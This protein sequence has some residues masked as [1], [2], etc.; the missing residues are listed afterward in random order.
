MLSNEHELML[1]WLKEGRARGVGPEPAEA[2]AARSQ[3]IHG[4]EEE[5]VPSLRPGSLLLTPEQA[6]EDLV[7]VYLHGGGFRSGTT[8]KARALAAQLA[9]LTG[10]RVL[11][12][13]YRLA[14]QHPYPAGLD[15]CEAGY[16]YAAARF[17]YA[18]MVLGG[19]SAGANLALALL[20]RRTAAEDPR[21]LAGFLYSGM[22]DLRAERFERGSWVGNAPTDFV[23][24][25]PGGL[26]TSADYAGK[27]EPDEPLISPVTADLAG[28]PPLLIQ[29]SSAE[30][31]LDD[32]LEL[33]AQAA[34]SRVR[35]VLE[36]QPHLQH[37]WQL[38]TGFLPEADHAVERTVD[39]ICRA[40][41]ER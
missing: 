38:F 39:F 35:V 30:M 23:L 28:L 5:Q 1:E 36:V 29:V 26:S 14:P 22:Y 16:L 13:E 20:L 31:L 6:R 25:V 9:Q 10:A 17:P 34:R 21:P 37:A 7:I 12:P 11:L 8:E 18:R 4:V 3:K 19:E 24:E 41:D 33:A 2:R 15:D 27:H 32:S 40:E